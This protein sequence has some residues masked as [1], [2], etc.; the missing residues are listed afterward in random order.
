VESGFYLRDGSCKL[1]SDAGVL[2]MY[3]CILLSHTE[4]FSPTAS[5]LNQPKREIHRFHNRR[6][7][8]ENKKSTTH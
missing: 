1:L 3:R 5:L 8:T 7:E 2:C 4:T 6:K